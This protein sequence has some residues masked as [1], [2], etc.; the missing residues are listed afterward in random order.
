M[1]KLIG[2]LVFAVFVLGGCAA[3]RAFLGTPE[4]EAAVETG[5]GSGVVIASAV[6]PPP[7]NM[8]IPVIGGLITL[9]LTG[10]DDG[11]GT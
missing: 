3:L 5:V 7:F 9:L 6:I 1:R 4:G 11:G 10:G 8:L 2:L